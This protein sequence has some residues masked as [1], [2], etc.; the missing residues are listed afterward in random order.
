MERRRRGRRK[1]RDDVVPGAR[2]A[3]LV[4][5]VLDA[6]VRHVR[7]SWGSQGWKR[8]WI[9][10]SPDGATRL[11]RAAPVS[12]GAAVEGGGPQRH[13]ASR[14]AAQEALEEHDPVHG[15]GRVEQG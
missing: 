1:V 12:Q 11:Q 4:E 3:L 7:I 5:D 9:A 8:P 13:V 10:P 14:A 2:D 6:V 15:P